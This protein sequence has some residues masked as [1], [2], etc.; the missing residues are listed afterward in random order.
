MSVVIGEGAEGPTLGVADTRLRERELSCLALYTVSAVVQHALSLLWHHL[1]ARATVVRP[2]VTGPTV[3]AVASAVVVLPP[4]SLQP[5]FL[6]V[7]VDV[8]SNDETDDV[9]ERHPGL[10][11]QE[12]LR[13]RQGDG[14]GDPRDLHDRHEAG[15]HGGA[16]LVERTRSSND[17]HAEEVYGVLD[18]RDLRD[19]VSQCSA[20]MHI[21]E[22]YEE[23]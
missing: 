15:A 23:V 14:R 19:R 2:A 12:S 17:G 8:G 6:G 7:S 1:V 10:L 4:E 21:G 20:C 11:G 18:R 16:D 9:E 13:K 3:S 22:T 5:L